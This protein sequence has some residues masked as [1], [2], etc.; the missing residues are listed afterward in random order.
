MIVEVFPHPALATAPPEAKPTGETTLA[1]S[2]VA[3]LD[4]HV[5]YFY[6]SLPKGTYRFAFRTPRRTFATLAGDGGDIMN[7]RYLYNDWLFIIGGF[8][9]RVYKLA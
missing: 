8:F 1:P 7:S 2:Y 5:A 4:D 6:D 3:F 9:Q